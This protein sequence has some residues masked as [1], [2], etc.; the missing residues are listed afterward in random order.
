MNLREFLVSPMGYLA[1]DKALDGLS[2]GEASH[3]VQGAAHT[4]AEIVAHLSYWQDWFYARCTGDS[5]PMATSAAAGWPGVQTEAWPALRSHF[6][7]RLSL[8]AT[9]GDADVSRRIAPS[10]EFPPLASYTI[11]DALVHVATHNAHHLGQVIVLRQLLGAWPRPGGSW[12][13]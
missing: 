4:V 3:K 13:W 1:P 5:Q 11:G 10:I 7:D 2:A 12:T 9:L 6:L 8:L